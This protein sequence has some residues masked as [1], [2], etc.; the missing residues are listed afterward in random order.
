MQSGYHSYE[1]LM[2]THRRRI[3]TVRASAAAAGL[4]NR[5]RRGLRTIGALRQARGGHVRPGHNPETL[6][7]A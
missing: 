3:E 2:A 6:F 7:F 1:A 5:P 4:A